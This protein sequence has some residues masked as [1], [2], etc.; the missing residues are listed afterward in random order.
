MPNAF[1]FIFL[2]L[3]SY[4]LLQLSYTVYLD[5]YNPA[6]DPASL[7]TTKVLTWFFLNA[8]FREILG[9]AKVQFLLDNKP[10]VNI[11]EACNGISVAMSLLAFLIA[12]K[13]KSK[14]YV[15]VVPV[16]LLLLFI[17]NMLRLYALV[18]IKMFY[19]ASFPFFHEYLFPGILYL[20]AF[21]IMVFWVKR[22][23]QP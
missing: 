15:W 6:I 20:I 18:Q 2:F 19:P 7:Y 11:K 10:V 17:A 14:D 23:Y 1:K 3:G 21:G 4:L 13:G 12:F 22:T 5:F 16:S 8:D 9:E